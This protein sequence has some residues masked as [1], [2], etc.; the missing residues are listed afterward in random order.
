MTIWTK[1][2]RLLP[3]NRDGK[4]PLALQ[5]IVFLLLE[6]LFIWGKH[7]ADGLVYASSLS[8]WAMDVFGFEHFDKALTLL[9]MLIAAE[10]CAW[11]IGTQRYITFGGQTLR[12][13]T[14]LPIALGYLALSLVT[15]L[16]SEQLMRVSLPLPT[17]NMMVYTI[18][19]S[20]LYAAIVVVFCALIHALRRMEKARAGWLAAADVVLVLLLTLCIACSGQVQRDMVAQAY[21]D[22]AA[23]QV[24]VTTIGVPEGEGTDD[25]LAAILSHSGLS[26]E[27]VVIVPAED[28]LASMQAASDPFAAYEEAMKPADRLADIL[29]WVQL[30][31]IFFAMKRWLFQPDAPK[32]AAA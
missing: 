14:V 5:L 16:L 23:Q 2:K 4:W 11:H 30:I 26:T 22:P 32:E 13:W 20:L 6:A 27:D 10:I 1:L 19:H 18:I 29:M 28:A 24:T 12:R 3:P 21:A 7:Q 15:W 17:D 25:L 8:T 31:P 9:S